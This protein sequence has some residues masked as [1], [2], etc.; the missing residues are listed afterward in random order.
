M[1]FLGAERST[2]EFQEQTL[3]RCRALADAN[4]SVR[5]TIGQ[6]RSRGSASLIEWAPKG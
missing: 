5:D 4:G 1:R 3:G 6:F 2:P